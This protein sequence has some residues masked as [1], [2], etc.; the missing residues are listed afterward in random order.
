MKVG[1]KSI[2]PYFCQMEFKNIFSDVPDFRRNHVFK[3]HLLSDILALSLCAS[4]AGA[5]TDEEIETYGKE[6][7]DFL[8]TFLSLPHGIPAH[9]TFTRVFRILD[10]DKFADCLYKYSKD[11]MEFLD[12]HHISIDGK[13]CRATNKGGR[14]KGGICIVTAWACE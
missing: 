5:E 10:K 9:D 7:L 1:K 3:K 11:I 6:K 12:E 4:L 8:K 14:K 13:I 2:V